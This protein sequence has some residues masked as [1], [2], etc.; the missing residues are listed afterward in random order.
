MSHGRVCSAASDRIHLI[1][2]QSDQ[3]RD[4][5]RGALADQGGQLVAEGLASA[6]RHKHEG[7]MT[8]HDARY[9]LGLITLEG[10]EAKEVLKGLV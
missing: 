10:V 2:H 8:G 3:W 4:D 5:D 9:D 1:L 6:G 7:V